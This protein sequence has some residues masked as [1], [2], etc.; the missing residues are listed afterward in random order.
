LVAAIDQVGDVAAQPLPSILDTLVAD[1]RQAQRDEIVRLSGVLDSL[2]AQ[3]AGLWADRALVADQQDQ[4]PPPFAGRT[5]SRTDRPGAP[6]W[7]LVDFAP[8]VD[9]ETAAALE[10][11]LEAANLLD[12]WVPPAGEPNPGA[13][14]TVL[15]ALPPAKRPKRSLLGGHLVAEPDAALPVST[16]EA[17]LASI[18]VGS[19][20][21]SAAGVAPVVDTS[22][23]FRQGIQLGAHHRPHAE[24]IGTTARARRRTQRLA[25]LDAQIEATDQEA[26]RTKEAARTIRALLDALDAARSALPPTAPL[27][28]AVRTVERESA[29]VRA[30]HGEVDNARSDLDQAIAGYH[31]RHRSLLALPPAIRPKRYL[32]VVHL[33]AEPDDDIA[34]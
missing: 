34:V 30:V 22:G 13:S 14:D 25:A 2:T 27:A 31:H 4:A 26:T 7:A 24:Y 9:D 15:L 1:A 16:I 8:G 12:A 29:T 19:P 11:A 17:V 18:A 20:T 3:L 23:G 10:A 32:L 28:Q 21:G 5:G 33:V 6:L